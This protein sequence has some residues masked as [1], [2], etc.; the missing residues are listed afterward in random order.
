MALLITSPVNSCSRS[1]HKLVIMQKLP[2]R[3]AKTMSELPSIPADVWETSNPYKISEQTLDPYSYKQSV[4]SSNRPKA[5]QEQERVTSSKQ[6]SMKVHASGVVKKDTL[7]GNAHMDHW[8]P[9][10]CKKRR[11]KGT[12]QQ[13]TES[14]DSK[15]RVCCRLLESVL[16]TVPLLRAWTWQ[17]PVASMQLF[18]ATEQVCHWTETKFSLMSL[19]IPFGCD[20]AKPISKWHVVRW[21]QMELLAPLSTGSDNVGITGLHTWQAWHYQESSVGTFWPRLIWS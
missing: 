7:L 20:N 6:R 10:M 16:L 13:N 11:L 15:S 19:N 4:A 14:K 12:C 1:T 8:D 9:E 5:W 21:N 17:L 3:R 18:L 2:S